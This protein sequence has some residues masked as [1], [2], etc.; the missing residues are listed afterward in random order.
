M[1]LKPTVVHEGKGGK[2]VH[3]GRVIG[4]IGHWKVCTWGDDTPYLTASGCN[5][6]ALWLQAGLGVVSVVGR[7]LARARQPANTQ[8]ELTITGSVAR[9]GRDVLSLGNIQIEGAA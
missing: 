2:L 1:I 4:H 8:R 6:P 5:I 3:Q 7:P 9:I